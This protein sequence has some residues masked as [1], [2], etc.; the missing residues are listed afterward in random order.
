RVDAVMREV[1]SEVNIDRERIYIAGFSNGG[2][3]ALYYATLWPQRFAAVASLMGA[4]QC[5]QEVAEGLASAANLPI[6]FVHGDKDTVVPES[7]PQ[8]TY[9]A[10][11]KMSPRVAPELRVLKGTE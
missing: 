3:G 9:D 4:G 2:T 11:N 8:A 5:M 6:L 10:L 1:A 7:A